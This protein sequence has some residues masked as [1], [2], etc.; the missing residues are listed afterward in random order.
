MSQLEKIQSELAE[1]FC[2]E[3]ASFKIDECFKS[4][5]SFIA[6]LKQV[7]LALTFCPNPWGW[8]VRVPGQNCQGVSYFGVYYIFI[9]KFFYLKGPIIGLLCYTPLPPHPPCVHLCL[10]GIMNFDIT[11]LIC[12]FFIASCSLKIAVKSKINFTLAITII[13]QFQSSFKL[14][15]KRNCET[16]R[17][18]F[19][20]KR[21]N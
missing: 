3:T 5:S 12:S 15:Y 9:N 14:D 21:L 19:R 16:A 11:S 10:K 8:G 7:L 18:F 4:F 2:E 1:F 13:I 20:R 17:L 6:K